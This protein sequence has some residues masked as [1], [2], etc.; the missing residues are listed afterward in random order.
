MAFGVNAFCTILCRRSPILLLT[1]S[2]SSPTV[3]FI[4]EF[5]NPL[6]PHMVAVAEGLRLCHDFG[7]FSSYAKAII[8]STVILRS[9]LAGPLYAFTEKNHALVITA[10]HQSILETSNPAY[11]I[12][13][14][15]GNIDARL[16]QSLFRRTFTENC[17]KLRCHP[18]K[19]AIFGMIQL[20]VWMTATFGLRNV[21]GYQITPFWYWPPMIPEF[22]TEGLTTPTTSFCLIAAT[23]F[24]T[25]L[26]VEISH[27]RRV[28][29]QAATTA[30]A[31]DPKLANQNRIAT[32]VRTRLP[33][34]LK[35][36]H[37]VGHL[38]TLLI[39]LFSSFAPSALVIFWCTS[40]SHQL[41][42]HLLYLSNRARR[43]LGVE[44]TPVDPKR[45]Y[46][47]LWRIAKS[48]YRILRLISNRG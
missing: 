23:T 7:H 1:R 24:V 13:Q 10:Y 37:R 8:V 33:W 43:L 22:V 27:L 25:A 48:H 2:W 36:A 40:A 11:S 41:M 21:C 42:L 4:S 18:L 19:S 17:Q 29:S 30:M 34:Q 32:V 44:K 46:L 31:L 15:D 47:A 39:T 20:P 28:Y 38:G 26:N 6:Q 9:A 14:K 16:Q 45:P 35:F 3:Y 12:R 5:F